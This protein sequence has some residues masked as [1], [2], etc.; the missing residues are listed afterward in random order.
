MRILV[1]RI[2]NLV[3]MF[4]QLP[5]CIDEREFTSGDD[6]NAYSHTNEVHRILH[7]KYWGNQ[8][9]ATVASHTRG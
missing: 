2:S 7:G 5:Y 9:A 6:E 4:Q 3:K 1:Y 8:S